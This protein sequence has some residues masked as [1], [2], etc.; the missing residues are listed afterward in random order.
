MNTNGI[1]SIVRR[2]RT[3][4]RNGKRYRQSSETL[5]AYELQEKNKTLCPFFSHSLTNNAL[6]LTQDI[7]RVS[8]IYSERR[9]STNYSERIL[10]LT[11]SILPPFSCPGYPVCVPRVCTEKVIGDD[12]LSGIA[13]N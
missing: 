9:V 6:E 2:H 7:A 3:G 12:M 10:L 5:I 8:T 11:F 4:L 1:C 13:R